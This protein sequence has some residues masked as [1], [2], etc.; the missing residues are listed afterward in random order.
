VAATQGVPITLALVVAAP[1]C[2]GKIA[3]KPP[4]LALAT[5]RHAPASHAGALLTSHDHAL[6][7][8]EFD[9]LLRLV[10]EELDE[11]FANTFQDRVVVRKHNAARV[12]AGVEVIQTAEG[13]LIKINVEVGKGEPLIFGHLADGVRE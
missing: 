7:G 13:A 2:W 1:L 10:T 5:F 8:G 9:E 4:R 6:G 3:A 11:G 12:H